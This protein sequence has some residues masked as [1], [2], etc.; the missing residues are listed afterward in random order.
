MA[1]S[2]VEW[3]ARDR[4]SS[5]VVGKELDVVEAGTRVRLISVPAVLHEG[6]PV[7]E[8]PDFLE[9]ATGSEHGAV[10]GSEFGS[11][12]SPLPVEPVELDAG[13]GRSAV[14]DS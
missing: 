13:E 12:L 2:C 14:G 10:Q 8:K 11:S 3:D 6:V 1:G 5:N 7:S 9:L 4:N